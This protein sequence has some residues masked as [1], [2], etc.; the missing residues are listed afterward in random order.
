MIKI[1]KSNNSK[2]YKIFYDYY[3]KALSRHQESIEAV[4]ISSLDVINNEVDSRAVNL[5]YINN[6]EWIFFSNYKSKKAQDFT[7]HD[8]ISALFFWSS[9]NTQIRIKAKIKKSKKVISE[10]HYSNRSIE[11]NALAASSNQ[12]KKIGSYKEVILNYEK[13]LENH[14]FVAKLPNNWG[15]YSFIPYYFEFW[16]G[17]KS[18]INKRD[19]YEM[20]N[21]EWQHFFLQP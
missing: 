15:G 20:K 5:K 3:K 11:K 21:N 13:T 9:I 6:D 16:E 17:H 10:N 19:V 14:Q 8:Q 1:T 18:R 2:P 7:S 12:S 4:Y